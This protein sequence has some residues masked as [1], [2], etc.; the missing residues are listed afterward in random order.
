[1]AEEILH[2]DLDLREVDLELRSS[3][4]HLNLDL[5]KQQATSLAV[6]QHMLNDCMELLQLF[7]VPYMVAP[8][9]AEAQCAKLELLGLCNGTITD[10]SDVWLF[11]GSHVLKNFFQRD[12]HVTSFAAKDLSN[13]FGLD[14]N[15]LVAL[16]L[17]CGSDY[18][19]GILGAGPVTAMEIL[20]E[21]GQQCDGIMALKSFK[22]WV[23]KTRSSRGVLSG[24]EVNS[25]TRNK[26]RRH[27]DAVPDTFPN[28]VVIDAYLNPRVEHSAESFAWGRIDLDLLRKFALKT[29]NWNSQKVDD[30]VCPVLRKM[31]SAETQSKVT[32]FFASSSTS[33]NACSTF[34]SKRLKSAF[35]K[36]LTSTIEPVANQT[37]TTVD[38]VCSIKPKPKSN[39][40]S[41][42]AN[43]K[44]SRANNKS[45]VSKAMPSVDL[46]SVKD[47]LS[48][49]EESDD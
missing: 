1:M 49:S 23:D 43:R 36:L 5:Q 19:D 30:L 34:Q 4:Y 27:A 24:N 12:R 28:P 33:I 45:K 17:V 31:N 15:K 40:K 16:A 41:K 48:L 29:L 46:G 38:Q 10:D 2:S 9:E 25:S 3:Q 22:A 32:D 14:R 13:I 44:K 37:S 18:T 42:A 26:L 6:T 21:F 11:G 20:S 7:G 39:P 8:S 47:R 35:S